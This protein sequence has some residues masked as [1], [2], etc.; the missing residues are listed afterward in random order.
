MVWSLVKSENNGWIM[1]R[2]DIFGKGKNLFKDSEPVIL[3]AAVLAWLWAIFVTWLWTVPGEN[4]ALPTWTVLTACGFLL[5]KTLKMEPPAP[6]LS[7]PF[8]TPSKKR[9]VYILCFGLALIYV[10][11]RLL[12]VANYEWRLIGWG[13]GVEA[14]GFTLIFV[15]WLAGLAGLKQWAFPIA[16]LLLA[17]PWPNLF[18][19]PVIAA[20]T[21][22]DV[23]VVTQILGWLDIPV[24]VR[25]AMLELPRGL[26]V[27]NESCSGIQSLQA[28]LLLAIFQGHY[29]GLHPQRRLGLV[30]AAALIAVLAN[31]VR[32]TFL[33][34]QAAGQGLAEMRRWHDL[35]GIVILVACFTCLWLVG[36]LL[37]SRNQPA[38]EA[39]I[40]FKNL[41]LSHGWAKVRMTPLLLALMVWFAVTEIEIGE[42]FYLHGQHAQP[43]KTWTLSWPTNNPTC[44]LGTLAKAI[45]ITQQ[46]FDQGHFATWSENGIRWQVIC[47]Q[48][49]EGRL[50]EHPRIYIPTASEPLRFPP[51]PRWL[52]ANGI[53]IPFQFYAPS[54]APTPTYVYFGF[55]NER[56]GQLAPELSLSLSNRLA[57]VTS[58]TLYP[59]VR[60]MEIIATGELH[61][62]NPEILLQ[63]ALAKLVHGAP[64]NLHSKVPAGS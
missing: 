50:V 56:T 17:I 62:Q 46:P 20:L 49:K 55:W 41:S 30:G 45:G 24:Q 23:A 54:N 44:R 43:D 4:G 60:C 63:G 52:D 27:I 6:S 64:P 51:E 7:S 2:T 8:A 16:F 21:R 15:Y 18:A 1:V 38:T 12:E 58:G 36:L 9:T 34:N 26:V 31:L 13:L 37:R 25:G 32:L 11:L 48:W 33:L 35:T 40:A 29:F 39:P 19:Q 28:C 53:R 57:F 3:L 59:P 5:W 14:V 10:P 47:L 61:G 42:W 22:F